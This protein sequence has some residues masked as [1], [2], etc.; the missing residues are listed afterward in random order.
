[1]KEH[2]QK[3]TVILVLLISEASLTSFGMILSFCV[4]TACGDLDKEIS[5][6]N[7]IQ[8]H[9][10]N[11]YTNNIED[12][13]LID[14]LRRCSPKWVENQILNDE[15]CVPD[16]ECISEGLRCTQYQGSIYGEKCLKLCGSNADCTGLKVKGNG[17]AHE[18]CKKCGGIGY[19]TSKES[20]KSS[21]FYREKCK[22]DSD[23]QSG[24]LCS[25]NSAGELMCLSLK[26]INADKGTDANVNTRGVDTESIFKKG[27]DTSTDLFF[28]INTDYYTDT[29][30]KRYTDT[31][32]QPYIDTDTDTYI[33]TNTVTDTNT[34]TNSGID[35]D[36]YVD[37]DTVV[38]TETDSDSGSD[39]GSDSDSDSDTEIS[40]C[41]G[42]MID[43]VCYG[44]DEE[45]PDNIC[46][47]CDASSSSSSWSDNDEE[48]CDDRLYCTENDVCIDGECR[49][50]ERSCDDGISCNGDELCDEDADT[51]QEGT[52]I[53]KD[54]ERCDVD[55]DV[56]I[57]QCI[58]CEISGSCYPDGTI[59][60]N[61]PCMICDVSVS[62]TEWTTNTGASCDDESLCTENDKC[63]LSGQC[64]GTPIS[65]ESDSSTC[66]I[67]RICLPETGCQETYPGQSVVCD[68]NNAC[69]YHDKCNGNGQCLGTENTCDDNLYCTQ[70]KCSNGSCSNT[71]ES[72][73]CLVGSADG[74]SKVC[75]SE[76]F[77]ADHDPCMVC[78]S[79]QN[80]SG[81]TAEPDSEHC[82][83]GGQCYSNGTAST[84]MACLSCNASQNRDGWS[85]NADKCFI[86]QQCYSPGEENPGDSGYVCDPSENQRA[87]SPVSTSWTPWLD[88]DNPSGNGDGEH[89][90]IFRSE[91]TV[92]DTPL[93]IECRRVEDH[94]PANQTGQI[95]VCSPSVG[96]ICI[97]AD[98]PD[99]GPGE[100]C[101]DDYEVRFLCR[102]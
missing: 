33:D 52:T 47:V 79:A 98:Q 97:N 46:L 44:N 37:T 71:L 81:W 58:G 24:K 38:G 36:T 11:C 42:C 101:C 28:H 22:D 29:D 56:C 31:E 14:G 96:L 32:T 77:R 100:K 30:T 87:W 20:F 7:E 17:I 16:D 91:G 86:D 5:S 90:D 72:N 73:Y 10:V 19:C 93:D 35:T 66:G 88:C 82:Y 8:L 92:C 21:C 2:K 23:C 9:M 62:K 60:E 51:C 76:G 25:P 89:L 50:D 61:R 69:T 12:Q 75:I 41:I 95:L 43:G 54:N 68:D 78:R 63:D 57:S 59:K 65:C 13:P 45:N 27:Y 53:C 34:D 67:K 39:S 55:R 6:N 80:A 3:S 49:G 85:I 83:I 99:C 94:V 102:D 48:P 26:E 18:W 40:N 64:V 1:M 74:L 15:E 70:D 4:M 84:A